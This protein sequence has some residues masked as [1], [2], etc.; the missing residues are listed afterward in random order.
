[1]INLHI[2]FLEDKVVV[3]SY[4]DGEWYLWDYV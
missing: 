3:K 4:K 2:N 1:M